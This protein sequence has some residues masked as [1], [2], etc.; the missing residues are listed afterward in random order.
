MT[1]IEYPG[2]SPSAQ[3]ESGNGDR[4][5]PPSLNAGRLWSAGLATAAVAAL[6]GFVGVLAGRALFGVALHAPDDVRMFADADAV[7][8][9]VGAAVAALAATGLV[10][11]LWLST[12]RPLTYFGWI[13]GLFTAA[14]VFMPFL[15]GGSLAVALIVAVI[16]L[17][18]GLAIGTLI[19]GAAAS[20]AR[21]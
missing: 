8:L 12:P 1:T 15:A 21:S 16:H 14:A 5:R 11:L 4:R 10:H 3:H 18:V 2:G 13:V 19:T 7:R 17:V 6:A 9:C 20:A